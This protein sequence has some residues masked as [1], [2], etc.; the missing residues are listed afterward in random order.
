M[1]SVKRLMR[2]ANPVPGDRPGTEARAEARLAELLGGPARTAAPRRRI[3]VGVAAAAVVLAGAV[4]VGAVVLRDAAPPSSPASDQ[5]F[6]PT[7]GELE[8]S[9]EAIVRGTVGATR[10]SAGETVATFAVSRVAT[11]TPRPGS[12]IRVVFS[13]SGPEQADGIRQGGEY[14]LLLQARDATSWNLVNTTQGYYT[15]DRG[16][17]VPTAGNPV[18][19]GPPTTTAL[20]L[21]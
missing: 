20:G 1:P 15:V 5:P 3:L 17:L 4:T 6:Y 8:G 18:T 13:A 21:S 14:V 16:R 10:A 9:A 19:L 11:G 12:S 7:A 2:D